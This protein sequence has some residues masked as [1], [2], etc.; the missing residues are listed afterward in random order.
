VDPIA[1][2]GGMKKEKNPTSLQGMNPWPSDLEA[3][4]LII[5]IRFVDHTLTGKKSGLVI[6]HRYTIIVHSCT[7]M[8]Y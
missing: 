6:M 4:V 8:C 2:L 3:V 5:Y 1:V 7:N